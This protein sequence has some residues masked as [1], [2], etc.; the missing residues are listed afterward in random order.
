VAQFFSDSQ[1]INKTQHQLLLGYMIQ[2]S[3]VK[4]QREAYT[5]GCL[6]EARVNS[7]VALDWAGR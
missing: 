4:A 2:L 5:D 3:V 6:E 1:C 7:T